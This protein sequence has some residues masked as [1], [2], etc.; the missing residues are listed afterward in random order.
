MTFGRTAR[1]IHLIGEIYTRF[2]EDDGWAIASH[3]AMSALMAL[4]PFLIFVTALGAIMG[5][6]N[7]Q[8]EIVTLLFESWP[9]VIAAPIA[10]EVSK[11][12]SQSRPGLLTIG[13]V[14]AFVLATNGVEAVRIGIN[15]AYRVREERG[16]WLCRLQG[17]LFVIVGAT[18]LVALAVFV[19][20]WPVLWRTAVRWVPPLGE[21]EFTA[22]ALRYATAFPIL[23]GAILLVHL[24]LAAGR[25]SLR[26]VLPGAALTFVLWLVSGAA[27]G[28]YFTDFNDYS[29]TYAGLAGV[30]AALFF[31]WLVSV[32]FL[33]GAELNA[34]L[35]SQAERRR[36]ATMA[37]LSHAPDGSGWTR[38]PATAAISASSAAAALAASASS[39]RSARRREISYQM[40]PTTVTLIRISASA[41]M[42]GVMPLRTFENT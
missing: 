22:E 12:L 23:V 11:V 18:A 5:T 26:D 10:E 36:M 28:V 27:F 42:V 34:I 7:L 30:V 16:F 35:I 21:L 32:V 14:L 25:R 13:A 3:M 38:P 8:A 29:K 6:P 9:P 37:A 24:Y 17:T 39:R 33:I 19:V 31:L 15:R 20:L 2:S 1:V 4:F 40:A 41:L